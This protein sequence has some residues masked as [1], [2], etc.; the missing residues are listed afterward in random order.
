MPEIYRRREHARSRLEQEPQTE[1]RRA[2]F[3]WPDVHDHRSGSAESEADLARAF[4]TDGRIFH[5]IEPDDA[6]SGAVEEILERR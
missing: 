6:G 4:R 1:L 2:A 5:G 3:A